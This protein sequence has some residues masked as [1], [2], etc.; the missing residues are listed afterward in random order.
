M[1][2]LSVS[3]QHKMLTKLLAEANNLKS[4]SEN[5]KKAISYAAFPATGAII[6]DTILACDECT[7]YVHNILRTN[8]TIQTVNYNLVK[9]QNTTKVI[10][11]FSMPSDYL[12]LCRQSHTVMNT[13]WTSIAAGVAGTSLTIANARAARHTNAITSIKTLLNLPGAV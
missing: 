4:I 5:A 9:S 8:N 2:T 12:M 7:T 6:D 1:A 11:R 3:D 10:E 13:L